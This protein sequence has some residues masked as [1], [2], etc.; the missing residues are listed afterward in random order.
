MSEP[1]PVR[2]HLT[3]S[4]EYTRVTTYMLDVDAFN[5]WCEEYSVKGYKKPYTQYGSL[6]KAFIDADR[7]DADIKDDL[8][9]EG[10][11]VGQD[12]TN[13]VHIEK[14]EVRW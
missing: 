13:F 7:D 3:K 5:T 9:H 6:I 12:D 10:V 2:I 8:W 4:I 14:A 11:G 1:V